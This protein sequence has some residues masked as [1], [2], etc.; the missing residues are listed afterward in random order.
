MNRLHYKTIDFL[1]SNGPGVLKFL[2]DMENSKY[3]AEKYLARQSSQSY[4]IAIVTDLPLAKT[5]HSN[6]RAA[7][8]NQYN[9]WLT[10]HQ[11]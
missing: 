10:V 3:G 8:T 4:E 1:L 5:D 9:D 2:G 11:F 7:V 6:L